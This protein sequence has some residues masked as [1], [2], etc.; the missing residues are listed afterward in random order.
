MCASKA[1]KNPGKNTVDKAVEQA[2]ARA[3]ESRKTTLFTAGAAGILMGASLAFGSAQAMAAEDTPAPACDARM[4]STVSGRVCGASFVK[5]QAAE[6]AAAIP[7]AKPAAPSA[8]V[9]AAKEQAKTE[10]PVTADSAVPQSVTDR[11][12]SVRTASVLGQAEEKDV[13]IPTGDAAVPVYN[14]LGYSKAE[15]ERIKQALLAANKNNAALHLT[16]AD[17]ITLEF[18]TGDTTRS[19]AAGVPISNGLAENKIT[20]RIKTDKADVTF[21]SDVTKSKLTRLVDIRRDY[22]VTYTQPKLPGRETDEGFSVSADGKTLI[23][24]YDSSKATP[25]RTDDVLK[26]LRATPKTD[27]L[28][29]AG[30]RDLSGEEYSTV[31]HEGLG[32]MPRKSHMH[33]AVDA[34]GEP[35]GIMEL[36]IMDGPYW[37]GNRQISFSDKDLHEEEA[38]AGDFSWD[39][40]AQKITVASKNHRVFKARLFVA[41]Y[42]LSYYGSIIA[43]PDGK[44]VGNTPRA[45]NVIFVPQ[46]FKKKADLAASAARHAVTADAAKTPTDAKYYNAS[47]ETKKAYDAALAEAKSALAEAGDRDDA[48]L[49]E[50]LKARIDNATMRLDRA[51]EEL[52]GSATVKDALRQSIAEDGT[53]ADEQTGK[54]GTGTQGSDAYRNVTDTVFLTADGKADTE[55]NA[56]A[57]KAKTAYDNALAEAKKVNDAQYATQ[58]ETDK[59]KENLYKA[60]R[61]LA[62]FSTDKERLNI[63]LAKYGKVNIGTVQD[64]GKADPTYQNSTPDEREY[65]DNAL[66][67]ANR[68]AKDPNA[69]QKEVN[70]AIASLEAAKSA[71]DKNATKKQA[72]EAQ[73]QQSHDNDA[74]DA[75]SVFYRNAKDDAYYSSDKFPAAVDKDEAKKY[76]GQYDESL[77]AAKNVLKDPKATQKQVDGAL[78]KLKKAE[79]NLHRLESDPSDLIATLAANF[80]GNR[81][82][83][84]FN[85][86]A[87][88]QAG[89]EQAKKDFLAYNEAYAQAKQIREKIDA[90]KAQSQQPNFTQT[91]IDE[92]KAKLDAARK[93]IET[94]ATNKS[95]LNNVFGEDA[96]V[97]DSAAWKNMKALADKAAAAGDQATEEEKAAA[98]VLKDCTQAAE[99]AKQVLEDTLPRDT[100]AQGTPIPDDKKNEGKQPSD[101]GFLDGVQTHSKGEA[102]QSDVDRALKDLR[103]ARSGLLRFGTKLGKLKESVLEDPQ[104][105]QSPEY[106]NTE[107][108]GDR[109]KLDAYSNALKEAKEKLADPTLSQADADAAAEKLNRAR[110]DLSAH[111]TDI[112]KLEQSAGI[113]TS[114]SPAYRNTANPHFTLKNNEGGYGTAPDTEKNK[115]AAAAKKAYDAALSKARALIARHKDADAAPADKPTQQEI[116]AALAALNSAREEISKYDTQTDLLNKELSASKAEGS[117][118]T[119]GKFEGTEEFLNADYLKTGGEGAAKEDNEYVKAYK[120]ALEKA[121]TLEA[122][123]RGVKK[124]DPTQSVP[125]AERPTQEQINRALEDLREAKENIKQGFKTDLTKLREEKEYSGGDFKKTPEYRNAAAL[126]AKG[127]PS[128]V[129]DM[130]NDGSDGKPKGFE[131]LCSETDTY[132]AD[133]N[134]VR[135]Q[136]EA[137]EMLQKLISAREKIEKYGTDVT[138][139]QNEIDNKNAAGLPVDFGRSAAYRN[140]LA[141]KNAGDQNAAGKISAY[142]EKLKAARDM[143]AR[144]EN[145]NG[146]PADRPTNEQVKEAKEALA[147]AKKDIADGFGTDTGA[148]QNEADADSGF[149]LTLPFKNAQYAKGEGGADNAD[150]AA[151]N[152]ALQAARELLRKAGDPAAA[153]ADKPTQ[154]DV[155]SALARL[156]RAKA[157]LDKYKTVKTDLSAEVGRD[158]VFRGGAGFANAAARTDSSARKAVSDYEQALA[159]ANRVLGD[160]NATQ[161]DVDSALA[162]LKRAKAALDKYK[163][164]RVPAGAGDSGRGKHSFA[165]AAKPGR[166]GRLGR[167]GAGA[168]LP[169]MLAALALGLGGTGTVARH[170]RRRGK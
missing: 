69:S 30:L 128:A 134:R 94:Y 112:S 43:R 23:Y 163:T 44:N 167:T 35:I 82:P 168:S 90:A 169:A 162:R 109:D 83:A 122:A 148:L 1:K 133:A 4:Q 145:Q 48:Q 56:R 59:A 47:L 9:P 113:P 124:A 13:V 2:V 74:P 110:A 11:S 18:I 139:L 123:A 132:L 101:P 8:S 120:D 70:A 114:D 166:T 22:N 73:V 40:E 103:S 159:D 125:P 65:Y 106:K 24:R 158:G 76:A 81:L 31:K 119:K 12:A 87:L 80:S 5:Q 154:A 10:K 27:A 102:L 155:D 57:L 131:T 91:E 86:Y 55:K 111:A 45:I 61:A 108:A 66:D 62:E 53:P 15:L 135:T 147:K 170:R 63:A 52:N 68:L 14:P 136:R 150:V 41:P 84:Y 50:A 46:T 144:Y 16:S 75:Q 152:E 29:K 3:V 32:G 36:G 85:S 89:N 77:A 19:G 137:D 37:F 21:T 88:S 60:R 7:G 6:P 153:Q 127:D 49:S 161:A 105:V 20:V 64:I 141:K 143:I 107:A 33:Y 72:L 34:N 100:D 116:D 146:D 121:R 104:T 156:K 78:E 130:K 138:P 17:Q 140:A 126:A 149:R 157:A 79:D 58:A 118:E 98:Q 117:D 92:A 95:Q 151:Y 142:E 160:S 97:R 129:K 26:L 67:E 96:A 54:A 115:Q 93:V 165:P 51:R 25:F 39:G 99:K 71:L 42:A 38:K 164:V 28:R